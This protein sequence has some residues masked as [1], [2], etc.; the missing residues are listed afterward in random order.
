MA[1]VGINSFWMVLGHGYEDHEE[2]FEF[3]AIRCFVEAGRFNISLLWRLEASPIV[4]LK[5][6]LPLRSGLLATYCFPSEAGL[7]QRRIFSCFFPGRTGGTFL[8]FCR[9]F[10]FFWGQQR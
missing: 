8:H 4:I 5:L 2:W 1:I 3:S 7:P 10:L 6:R 9:S